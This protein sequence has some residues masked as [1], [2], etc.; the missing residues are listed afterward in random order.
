MSTLARFKFLE[1]E[2]LVAEESAIAQE[3]RDAILERRLPPGSKL[4]EEQLAETFATTRARVRRVL[5]SLSREHIVALQPARGASVARPTPK[6][7]REVL[8]ARRTLEVGMV[9]HPHH[10]LTD[11]QTISLRAIIEAERQAHRDTN[12]VGMIRLSGQFHLELAISIGNRVLANMLH[13]LILRTSL[14]IALFEKN[15]G[16]C[17]LTCDHESLLT[18]IS[19][20]SDGHAARLMTR[21][22][23]EIEQNMDFAI[24]PAPTTSL[25]LLLRN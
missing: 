23:L 24:E 4:P 6:E 7:A 19:E 1:I 18:A 3:L 2:G 15:K 17:C 8:A 5:L 20:G 16:T 9:E 10:R 12:V 13:E 22:L 11:E 25:S 21:H 14:I